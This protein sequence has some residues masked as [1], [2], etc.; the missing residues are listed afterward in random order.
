MTRSERKAANKSA[1]AAARAAQMAAYEAD[2]ANRVLVSATEAECYFPGESIQV[3]D[4]WFPVVRVGRTF[5]HHLQGSAAWIYHAAEPVIPTAPVELAAPACKR[6]AGII[7]FLAAAGG[8]AP[9]GDLT[10]M[11]V[12]RTFVPRHG[13]LVRKAGSGMNLDHARSVASQAG[14]LPDDS[15]INDLLDAIATESRGGRHV[16]EQD[17]ADEMEWA[18]YDASLKQADVEAAWAES[19]D[20]LAA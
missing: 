5:N 19:L 7:A 10:A 15:D 13:R 12:H 16:S 11:D 20:R 2:K 18:A 3:G 1:H 9:C 4:T 8:L 17:R 6:P 14:Y